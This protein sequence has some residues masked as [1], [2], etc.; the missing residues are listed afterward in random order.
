MAFP[1]WLMEIAL[2]LQGDNVQVSIH[3]TYDNAPMILKPELE[4]MM[5]KLEKNPESQ[6]PY[7]EFLELVELPA[8]QSAMK[9]LYSISSGHGGDVSE[10]IKEIIH[11]NNLLMDKAEKLENEDRMA[12]TNLYFLLPMLLGAFKLILDLSVF[13]L[14]FLQTSY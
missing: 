14:A 1:Q 9:M 10:Q 2:L 13:M 8:I 7:L 11:R 6:K 4:I 3:K 12:G 5:E